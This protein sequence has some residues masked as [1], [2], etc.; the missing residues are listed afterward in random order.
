MMF[1]EK[2]IRLRRERGLSQEQLADQLGVTRQSVSKWESGAAMPELVKLISLSEMFDVTLDYLVKDAVEERGSSRQEPSRTDT[3][4]LERKLDD[5]SRSY[6]SSF[7]PV[8]AYT[9]RLRLFGVPLLCVRFGRE[10]NPTPR[11]TAVGIVAVG[12]FAL[13]VVSLGLISAGLFSLGMISFGL[14]ALGVVAVG[15]G[16]LG[17]TAVGVY[18]AGV[19][20]CALKIAVG[21][22][23]ASADTAVGKEANAVHTLLW[24]S[25]LTREEVEA[26]LLA[27]HDGLWRPLVRLLS[28]FGAHIQ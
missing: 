27:H 19:S 10:R 21:V 14:L 2:L 13:G 24:G 22:A 28:F 12:N 18:A 23:A 5:L 7:G 25:G 6:R 9:S 4:R 17:V 8:F 3:A 16:A 15:G 11:T 26:F 20:A 1:S